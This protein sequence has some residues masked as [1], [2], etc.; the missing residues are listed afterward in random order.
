MPVTDSVTPPHYA[1]SEGPREVS[2]EFV[3]SRTNKNIKVKSGEMLLAA[4]GGRRE[5]S[6][7]VVLSFT[8]TDCGMVTR[9]SDGSLTHLDA[10]GLATVWPTNDRALCKVNTT[11]GHRRPFTGPPHDFPPPSAKDKDSPFTTTHVTLPHVL[12]DWSGPAYLHHF[13][14][15]NSGLRFYVTRCSKGAEYD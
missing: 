7:P 13:K 6:L 5:A 11:T 12:W 2:T 14:S 1:A 3:N 4:T 10:A 8:M 9:L 15:G